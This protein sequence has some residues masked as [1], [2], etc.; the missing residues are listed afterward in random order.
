MRDTDK[1]KELNALR[2]E[3][4]Q[5]KKDIAKLYDFIEKLVAIVKP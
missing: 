5:M 3:V 1:E 2:E 4:E